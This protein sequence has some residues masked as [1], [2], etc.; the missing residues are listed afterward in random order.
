[1]VYVLPGASRDTASPRLL[2]FDTGSVSWLTEKALVNESTSSGAAL[3]YRAK[4][5]LSEASATGLPAIT[6]IY[7]AWI[8]P[9]TLLP[10]KF[11]DE[12]ALYVLKFSSDP[13]AGPLI[14]P[15]NLQAELNR[16]QALLGPHRRL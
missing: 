5:V 13:P 14:M 8:D 3:H 9:K 6:A 16:W 4:V 1:S 12:S 11:E 2:H 15:A 7:Q 10:M